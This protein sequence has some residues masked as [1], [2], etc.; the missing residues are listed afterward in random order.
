MGKDNGRLLG[1]D[2]ANSR[3]GLR[4]EEVL[5]RREKSET[6]EIVALHWPLLW[7]R[8]RRQ[9]ANQTQFS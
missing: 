6:L 1:E 7:A 5:G 2:A 3:K 9:T 8:V 4:E